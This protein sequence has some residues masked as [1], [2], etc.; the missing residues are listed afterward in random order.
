MPHPREQAAER[1]VQLLRN[2]TR[3][4]RGKQRGPEHF[5]DLEITLGQLHCLRQVGELGQ[6]T[7]GDLADRL[8]LSPSTV[9]G[10]VDELVLRGLVERLED[11][12]DR[13]IVRVALTGTGRRHRDQHKRVQQQRLGRV[14]AA[15]S[16]E[17]LRRIESALEHL[18]E[19]VAEA[20][21][22]EDPSVCREES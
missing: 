8:R 12:E 22:S 17:D 9:T 7:M 11:A 18:N 14:F 6:P 4:L 3:T 19:V 21:E 13:R 10:L 16:D 15:L 1:I 20:A 5:H 2:V